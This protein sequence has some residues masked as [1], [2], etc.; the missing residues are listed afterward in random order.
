MVGQ[1]PHDDPGKDLLRLTL[2]QQLGERSLRAAG[3][4]FGSRGQEVFWRA[5]DLSGER[6]PVG[7]VDHLHRNNLAQ[8]LHRPGRL[9]AGKTIGVAAQALW[10]PG[11]REAMTRSRR[12]AEGGFVVRHGHFRQRLPQEFELEIE[13]RKR[14]RMFLFNIR[15]DE[16]Q[17]RILAVGGFAQ[18]GINGR[19]RRAQAR[20]FRAIK[21]AGMVGEQLVELRQFGDDVVGTVPRKAG[22]VMNPDF[23]G[24]E[25]F[26]AAGEAEPAARARQRAKAV[27]QQRPGTAA[28]GQAV[29]V[30]RFAVMHVKSDARRSGGGRSRGNGPLP[31][32]NNFGTVRSKPIA[33]R[34]R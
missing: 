34:L 13:A 14:E 2:G 22:A 25:P 11:R 30:M 33:F 1:R 18:Q 29:V 17:H 28:P 7:V 31:A 24:G 8:R 15:V 3:G 16:D 19:I 20:E 6:S 12:Q 26:H 9:G 32:R 27:S 21:E 4:K 23:F 5:F 10:H